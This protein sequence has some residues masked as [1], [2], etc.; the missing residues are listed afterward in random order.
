MLEPDLAAYLDTLVAVHGGADLR[1]A[2]EAVLGYDRPAV[3]G[4][5]VSVPPVPGVAGPELAGL[6]AGLSVLLE[7][8]ARAEGP[9]AEVGPVPSGQGVRC[10]TARVKCRRSWLFS[11]QLWSLK[12]LLSPSAL[13]PPQVDRAR[14]VLR[15]SLA[16]RRLLAKP[17]AGGGAACGGRL[18]DCLFL[19][20]ALAATA[21]AALESAIHALGDAGAPPEPTT[22][23]PA[24]DADGGGGSG[25]AGALA[26]A[27]SLLA[28]AAESVALSPGGV[29]AGAPGALRA[30]AVFAAD[31]LRALQ[32]EADKGAFPRAL[33]AFRPRLA[34]LP[35]SFSRSSTCLEAIA[36]RT[37]ERRVPPSRALARP[38]P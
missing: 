31:Q 1:S 7:A 4:K 9:A 28:A 38:C 30:E 15:L 14:S 36:T 21:R 23:A 18:K 5:A 29:T 16:A 12:C 3:K 2:A 27:L 26:G 8:D 19:D 20:A 22:A 32:T 13:P 11:Q 6:L 25:A 24:S 37:A 10:Q 17:I 33:V 34:P 35:A